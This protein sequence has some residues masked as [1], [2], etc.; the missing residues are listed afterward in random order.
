MDNLF[1][2]MCS[3]RNHICFLVFPIYWLLNRFR[4]GILEMVNILA[5][6]AMRIFYMFSS[7]LPASPLLS[8]LLLH[9]VPCT[10]SPPTCPQLLLHP[11][12]PESG[13]H[14]PWP[15]WAGSDT[16]CHLHATPER[17]WQKPRILPAAQAS[18]SAGWTVNMGA[19]ILPGF[20]ADG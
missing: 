12:T 3:M 10:S 13:L 2:L 1:L 11:G 18:R 6:L 5:G 19:C 14:L 20:P 4:Q 17:T 8:P 9:G 15:A 16:H 7:P